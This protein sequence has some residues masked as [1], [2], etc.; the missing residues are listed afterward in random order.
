M[1]RRSPCVLAGRSFV[2]RLRDFLFEL[3]ISPTRSQPLHYLSTSSSHWHLCWHLSL[4]HSFLLMNILQNY[5]S[6]ASF[7]S[8]GPELDVVSYFISVFYL[9]MLWA[10]STGWK[11]RW[12]VKCVKK[13]KQLI[14]QQMRTFFVSST[15]FSSSRLVAASKNSLSSGMPR[16]SAQRNGKKVCQWSSR[17]DDER[18]SPEV[19]CA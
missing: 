2:A 12:L 15:S 1:Q 5:A 17:V 8:G 10:S 18:A 13:M 14:K 6:I 11:G 19:L 3:W 7:G 16:L 4:S 9:L